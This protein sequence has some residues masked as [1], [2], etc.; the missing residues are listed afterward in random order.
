MRSPKAVVPR[1][2]DIA[3]TR[4]K[5]RQR[6]RWPVLGIVLSLFVLEAALWLAPVDDALFAVEQRDDWPVMTMQPDTNYT[7]IANAVSSTGSPPVG[8]FVVKTIVKNL[9][10]CSISPAALPGTGNSVTWNVHMFRAPPAP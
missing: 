7:V 8:A 10:S 4:R 3:Q 1:P 6:R 9:T 2:T 5:G